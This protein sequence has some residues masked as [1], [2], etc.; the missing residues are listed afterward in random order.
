MFQHS[1]HSF[2]EYR[3]NVI[4]YFI[5]DLKMC[6]CVM[7]GSANLTSPYF[8]KIVPGKMLLLFWR[9]YATVEFQVYIS[10]V[11]RIK[12]ALM[13]YPQI[14]A[15]LWMLLSQFGGSGVNVSCESGIMGAHG[16]VVSVSEHQR[17]QVNEILKTTDLSCYAAREQQ[18]HGGKTHT[19]EYIYIYTVT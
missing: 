8:S 17:E 10:K 11:R 18:V 15:R 5:D 6:I 12:H 9:S 16:P 13:E 3:Y 4:F 1:N 7:R 19:Y 2:C 14:H